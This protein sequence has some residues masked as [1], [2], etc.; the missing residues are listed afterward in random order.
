MKNLLCCLYLWTL[1]MGKKDFP[2]FKSVIKALRKGLLFVSLPQATPLAWL[3][4]TPVSASQAWS[5]KESQCLAPLALC[6]LLITTFVS[7]EPSSLWDSSVPLAQASSWN[8]LNRSKCFPLV[9]GGFL[10]HWCNCSLKNGSDGVLLP[11]GP[12]T[13]PLGRPGLRPSAALAPSAFSPPA[14]P[15]SPQWAVS[16]TQP[17]ICRFCSRCLAALDAEAQGRRDHPSLELTAF[18]SVDAVSWKFQFFYSR[19][20]F[21]MGHMYHIFTMDCYCEESNK[22][23]TVKLLMNIF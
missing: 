10:Q 20:V 6:S 16:P 7:P 11:A 12:P 23:L 13:W 21:Y 1:W 14:A 4:G 17:W 18:S 2:R 9:Y 3:M 8:M 5:F 22:I 15:W 19:T